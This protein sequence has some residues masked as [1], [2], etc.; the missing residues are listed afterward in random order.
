LAFFASLREILFFSRKDAKIAKNKPIF[1]KA[2]FGL[3][4]DE[5]EISKEVVDVA[6]GDSSRVGTTAL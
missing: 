4:M 5:N 3:E 2:V 6:I 1:A